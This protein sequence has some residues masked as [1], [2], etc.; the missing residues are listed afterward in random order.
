MKAIEEVEVETVKI[1]DFLTNNEL[2]ESNIA[3]W[4]DVEGAAYEV[5]TGFGNL[6]NMVSVIHVELERVKLYEEDHLQIEVENFL[7]K[8]DFICWG[9]SCTKVIK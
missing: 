6:L 5:I 3:V 8:N 4:I 1:E 2:V 7:I 9:I